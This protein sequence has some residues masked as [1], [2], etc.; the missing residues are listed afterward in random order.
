MLQGWVGVAIFFVIS[1]FCIHLSYER[2]RIKSWVDFFLR[3][4][5]RIYPPYLIALLFFAFILPYS[6][7]HLGT[8]SHD[9]N[10]VG[11]ALYTLAGHFV[12]LHRL[13]FGED[14]SPPFWSIATEVKLYL[15]YPLLVWLS[16]RLGWC[17]TIW[18]TGIIEI[19]LRIGQS[20]HVLGLNP[21]DTSW[22]TEA[23]LY[24]WFSW[25]IGAWIAECHQKGEALPFR[26]LPFLLCVGLFV[27]CDAVRPL[28]PF[29]FTLASLCTARVISTWLTAPESTP[30]PRSRWRDIF[31]EHLR[32][33]GIVSY[34]IYLLHY[35]L[36]DQLFILLG[37]AAP[38][39]FNKGLFTMALMLVLL[40]PMWFLI[41]YWSKSFHRFVELT[42][43][44]LG[45]RIIQRR[46]AAGESA[47]A[48]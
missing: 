9:P 26:R 42:S 33:A 47:A 40:I 7:L 8:R 3:R 18:L 27:I 32:Q 17:K 31:S 13:G 1:G 38:Q 48:A 36:Q 19:L 25:S 16:L 5:F 35:P 28:Y 2:S 37:S 41:F 22:Y 24:F 12:F 29:S 6:R 39:L 14:I 43:I 11:T 15:L 20:L 30:P 4:F 46:R 21:L 44:A 23:P 34:S 45:N 10:A